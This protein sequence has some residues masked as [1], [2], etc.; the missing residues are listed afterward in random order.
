MKSGLRWLVWLTFNALSLYLV[1]ALY[2]QRQLAFAILG[3]VVTG[4]AS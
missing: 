3:L 4:I 1:V 2:A